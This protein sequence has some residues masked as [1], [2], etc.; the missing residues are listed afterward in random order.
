MNKI[1][2]K[3]TT[4]MVG[5]VVWSL[6]PNELLAQCKNDPNTDGQFSIN[7]TKV[8]VNGDGNGVATASNNI[9][10]KICEGEL[11]TLQS[12]LPVNSSSYVGY[13]VTNLS[14]YNSLSSPPSNTGSTAAS[15]T[16]STGSVNLRMIDKTTTNP[17]GL[18]FYTGPGEYVITQYQTAISTGGSTITTHTCQVIKIIA[19][20]KPVATV[21]ACSGQEVQ[22][23]LP[24]NAAN[25]FD[26]YEIQFN[27]TAGNINPILKTGKPTSY[28]FTIK[29][30]TTLP[31]AQDR[32][33]TIKGLSV[34]GSCPAPLNTLG[35]FSINGATMYRPTISTIIGTT[36]KGE[37]KLAV[38]GQANFGRNIYMR[39]SST[40]YNYSSVLKPYG[41]LGT[42]PFDSTT[43]QVPNGDKQY[44]FQVEA[45]DM[46]CATSGSGG[47]TVLSAEEIC[48]TPAKVT[49]VSDKNVIEWLPAATG[50]IGGIFNFYQVERLNSN[51]TTDKVFPAI[52]NISELK[53]E[54][55][56]VTCGQEYTY[57]VETNYNQKSLSQ[58]IKVKAVSDNIPSKI[59]LV[60]TTINVD[61]QNAVNIQGRF[62]PITPNDVASYRLYRADTKNGNYNALTTA[63]MNGDGSF[64][65]KSAEVDKKSYCYYMTYTNLCNKES[66]PSDKICTIHISGN[67]NSIKWTSETPFSEPVG[68]YV[69]YQIDPSTKR[70]YSSRPVLVDNFNGNSTDKIARLPES[71]G[72][73]IFIQVQAEPSSTG[74]GGGNGRLGTSETNIIRIFR[75]SLALIPQIFTPNGDGQNDKFMVRGKFIKSLKM[76]IY[77][78]WGNAV[79]YDETNSY[80]FEGDQTEN[81]VVGWEGIMNNGNKAMEGSYAYK[82]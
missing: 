74:L 25:N 20:E 80:P 23:T 30:G 76:T 14:S 2:Q 16:T 35:K 34:T 72:Q 6:M 29:S 42:T 4:M 22:I 24:A 37:F 49:A 31:D 64:I 39:E 17:D 26:D 33:I 73:E 63:R 53:V 56:T 78:R 65:D 19:P 10:V 5:I 71:D 43:L 44:C 68:Y 58:I 47:T 69:A 66:E 36:K 15:Y 11:L 77:D 1:I 32:I 46:A 21:T 67:G 3:I 61:D 62:Q 38:S 54:D 27:A 82:I 41:S 59:P 52:T 45:V 51:G 79:F 55:N 40:T 57:R 50:L 60:Y 12:T 81:T 8:V 75:P 28:P 18:S 48:T 7:G 9:S 70:P 13:W